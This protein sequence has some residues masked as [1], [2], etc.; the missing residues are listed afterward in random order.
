[1]VLLKRCLPFALAGALTLTAMPSLAAELESAAGAERWQPTW[2]SLS[3][4]SVPQW[5]KDAKFGIYAHWGV[6]S[7][8]GGWDRTVPNWGNYY[9]L[10]YRGIYDLSGKD[11]T[12]GLFEKNVGPVREGFGYK[13]LARQF[14]PVDFDPEEWADLIVRSGAR[15]AGIA[16]MHHDGYAMWDSDVIRLD[17]GELGPERDLLGEI[18][19]AIKARGLKT[20]TSFHHAR[21]FRHFEVVQK[22]LR[23]Q[24]GH[25]DVDLLDAALR[26]YY[27]YAGDQEHFSSTRYRLTKEVI[28]KYEPDVIWFDGGGGKFGTERILADFFNM[29]ERAG[30]EVVVHNK[31][32]F[33]QEFGVYS[34][35]N[36]YDRPA[37]VNW[38][39]EDDTPSAAD[40]NHWPWA[41][42]MAY[43]KPR[44]VV[45]RL[46]DL[47]ARNGGLLLSLNPRPDG[48]LDPGQIDLLLGI[49]EWLGQ[50]GAAIYDTVPWKIF[51]EGNEG[52]LP[53]TVTGP[54]GQVGRAVQPDLS[55]LSWKD[56]RF[57]RNGETLYATFL[58]V[59]PDGE[60]VIGSLAS[61]TRVSSENRIASVSLLGHGKVPWVRDGSG[62]HLQL[63]ETLPNE[64]AL[65]FEITVDGELDKSPPAVDST[66]MKMPKQ[67]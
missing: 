2:A 8:S 18:L 15:Y 61:T 44:D 67:T 39:W 51:A 35:E 5:A 23:L 52:R 62:L 33:P 43:K 12:F 29:A 46:V 16:A 65:S 66:R 50:N 4:H 9:I 42:G 26:D 64:W 47:V 1:M 56:V 6:Y 11:E 34:Y 48:R 17:A 58:G 21:T 32:N 27:W 13:D 25:E 38:P 36:G 55:K 40:Y 41:R 19:A 10:P 7:V 63:P 28:D 22:K 37:Y 20:M 24:P 54:D 14:K 45:I 53:F 60:A 31:G 57:T 59:P 30:K 49:G 3:Q